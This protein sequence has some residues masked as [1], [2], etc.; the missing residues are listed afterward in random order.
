MENYLTTP[1]IENT[2][3]LKPVKI[4]KHSVKKYITFTEYDTEKTFCNIPS[5]DYTEWFIL[6]GKVYYRIN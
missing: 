3:N 2:D 4:K 6:K 1:T 5:G